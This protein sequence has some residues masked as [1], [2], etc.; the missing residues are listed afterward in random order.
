MKNSRRVWF[1][2]QKL[3]K[4]DGHWIM[5]CWPR[6]VKEEALIEEVLSKHPQYF[7][8]KQDVQTV[9]EFMGNELRTIELRGGLIPLEKG[10]EF[11]KLVPFYNHLLDV[12][13]FWKVI[14]LA[15]A[16]VAFFLGSQAISNYFEYKQNV[17]IYNNN[18]IERWEGDLYDITR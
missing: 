1:I 4:E 13:G 17:Q 18:N 9:L 12:W 15:W 3:Y 16:V 14:S 6:M 7:K 10:K 11:F 2:L 8:N 5:N